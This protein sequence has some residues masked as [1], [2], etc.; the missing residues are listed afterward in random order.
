VPRVRSQPRRRQHFQEFLSVKSAELF[1]VHTALLIKE[2]VGEADNRNDGGCSPG[3]ASER[4][5]RRRFV[6]SGT[7]DV[8]LA[9]NLTGLRPGA[10]KILMI[11]SFVNTLASSPSL[12]GDG[13][14]PFSEE[15]LELRRPEIYPPTLNCNPFH[16]AAIGRVG[17]DATVE[18]VRGSFAEHEN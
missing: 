10:R 3:R 9:A 12:P 11:C 15:N 5:S 13:L 4:G 17:K 2:T 16:S 8:V 18:Y 7:A 1:D 14:Y 6:K